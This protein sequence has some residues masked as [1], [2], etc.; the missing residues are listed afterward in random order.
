MKL[1][2]DYSC[3]RQC[4]DTGQRLS[5]NEISYSSGIC[6]R[7]GDDGRSTFAHNIKL[8]GKFNRPNILEWVMGKR[9]IF[10]AKD[11]QGVPGVE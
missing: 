7:C 5:H 11:Q 3:I 1:D 4:P 2:K 10:V 6:P 8:V 9:A